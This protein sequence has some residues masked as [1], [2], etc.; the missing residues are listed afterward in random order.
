MDVEPVAAAGGHLGRGQREA[1]AGGAAV[2][3]VVEQPTPPAAEVDHATARA[4]PDLLGHV[5][6]LA[7]LG[8]LEGEGVIAVVLGP[9]EVRELSQCEPD[10]PIGER[11]A[12]VDVLA[13][14]HY[15]SL[16]VTS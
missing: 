6:V 5:V 4:D 16:V 15:P 1:H 12:E 13:L 14:G 9:A 7:A 11:I 8:L 3:H 2:A 10:H